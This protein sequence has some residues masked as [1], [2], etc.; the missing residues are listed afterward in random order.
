MLRLAEMVGEETREEVEEQ[1]NVEDVEAVS[2]VKEILGVG[3][4]ARSGGRFRKGAV[5]LHATLCEVVD[6]HNSKADPQRREEYAR[7]FA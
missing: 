3:V 6:F 4:R 7:D 2:Q 1:A 5:L